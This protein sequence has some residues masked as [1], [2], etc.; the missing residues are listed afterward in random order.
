[1]ITFEEV[2]RAI[3]ARWVAALLTWLFVL[4]AVLAVSVALPPKYEAT[5]TVAVQMSGR[6]PIA[7]Q[8]VFHPADRISTYIATQI[9]IIKSEEVAVSALRSLGLHKQQ[10]WLDK[11]RES[12]GGAGNFESWLAESLL[13]KLDVRPAS[14]ES[15][16][17]TVSY[18]SPDAEFSAAAANA[19]V[20]SYIDT[21]LKMQVQPA[22]RFNSFFAERAKPLRAELDRARARLSAYEKEHGVLVGDQS[23]VESARLAELTSQL[24]SLQDEVARAGSLRKQARAAPGDI[25]EV[26]NDPQVAALT[27][28]LVR[29]EGDLAELKSEFGDRHHA[30]VQARQ[31]IRDVKQRLDTA[32]RRAAD[33]LLAP[34]KVVETRLAEVQTAIERQRELVIRRKAERDAAAALLRDVENAEKAYG[35][36]LTRASETALESANTNQT[37]ISVLK[38]A[39]PP[40]WSPMV[41]I[42]NASIATLLGLL[43]GLAAALRAESRDRRVRTVEDITR[44][45]QQ[46]FL[47]V[48]P[49]GRRR[50]RAFRSEQ[51]RR[52]LVSIQPR[53]PAPQ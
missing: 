10:E 43:L 4:A 9:D 2:L 27:G 31:S 28:E 44:R 15:N 33:G 49:D 1:M 37:S 11:W 24:V 20:R 52:R 6:D 16:V 42:R 51:T 38:S 30:V 47:L 46:P 45:L 7:G 40:V 34:V 53:L 50:K 18:S 19:F 35:A 32:M 3:K 22:Q 8:A 39:T 29:L 23:D 17:L 48:L 14:R 13:R 26:R 21:T 36:V 41:L 5:A 25:R 12:T